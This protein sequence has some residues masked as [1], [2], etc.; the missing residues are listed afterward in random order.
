[1]AAT[2]LVA[3]ARCPLCD[4]PDHRD[5]LTLPDRFRLGEA[6]LWRLVRCCNCGGGFLSEL[7][8]AELLASCY[9]TEG[10]DP[11]VS[12]AGARRWSQRVYIFLRRY[13]LSIRFHKLGKPRRGN[14]LL[15]VGCGTG[16]FLQRARRSGW[17][18][19]GVEPSEAAA[20]VAE[21]LGFVV[22]RGDLFSLPEPMQPYDAITFWHTLEHIPEPRAALERAVALLTP[23]GR[24][25]AAVPNAT[26]WDA[27]I[28]RENWIAYD[29]PRHCVMFTPD[30]LTMLFE[31]VGFRIKSSAGLVFDLGYNIIFS[32]HL[33]AQRIGKWSP[34]TPVRMLTAA[35]PALIGGPAGWSVLLMVAEKPESAK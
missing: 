25:V 26:S 29:A 23:R 10:Y 1:M 35:I 33:R 16:E 3:V 19:F 9:P 7:P 30:A 14:R 13:S 24:I 12:A 31:A 32:E 34:F 11:F 5:W 4:S 8:A 17:Q 28:Y 21:R 15:D 2:R 20:A 6:I 18:G 22:H 27:R